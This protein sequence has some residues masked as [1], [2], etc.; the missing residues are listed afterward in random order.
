MKKKVLAAVLSLSMILSTGVVAMADEAKDPADVKVGVITDVGGVNDGSFNQSRGKAL[1]ERMRNWASP[2]TIWN[3]IP[4][5]II[6]RTWRP[7]SMKS[8]I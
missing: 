4:I 2:P 7:S 5:P 3:P 1:Q 6:F 8:M